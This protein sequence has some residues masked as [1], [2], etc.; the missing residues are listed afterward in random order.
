MIALCPK[1]NGLL[2]L[3]KYFNRYECNKCGYT[4]EYKNEDWIDYIGKFSLLS[5][6]VLMD[7]INEIIRVLNKITNP[8]VIE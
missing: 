5:D 4:E 1:C 7:K 8:R 3:N 2:S 6:L